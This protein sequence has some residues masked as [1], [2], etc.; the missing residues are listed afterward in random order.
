M[1]W[2]ELRAALK[3]PLQTAESGNE[4]ETAHAGANLADIEWGKPTSCEEGS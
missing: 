3:Y 1:V 4:R 2:R